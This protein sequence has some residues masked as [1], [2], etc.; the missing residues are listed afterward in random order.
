MELLLNLSKET[1]NSVSEMQ[2]MP[3]HIVFGMYNALQKIFKKEE[4]N[5][6]KE[7]EKTQSTYNIPSIDQIKSQVGNI[8]S[9]S[10]KM[11]SV[12]NMPHM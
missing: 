5:S 11:P 3:F 12:P 4:E 2:R 10:I 1:S 8:Q 6:K 7:Q 9:G